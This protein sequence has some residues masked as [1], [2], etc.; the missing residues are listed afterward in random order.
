MYEVIG[1]K[2]IEILEIL[3]YI[4]EWHLVQLHTIMIFEAEIMWFFYEFAIAFVMRI[5]RKKGFEQRLLQ[6]TEKWWHGVGL[7]TN[8]LRS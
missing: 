6:T 3:M 8:Y 2:E 1:F 4:I 7:E 5:P